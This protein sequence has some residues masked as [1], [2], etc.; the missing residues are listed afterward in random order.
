MGEV[1][2]AC[3]GQMIPSGYQPATIELGQFPILGT[4]RHTETSDEP[5]V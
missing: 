1:G 5:S 4:Q 2:I 3:Q